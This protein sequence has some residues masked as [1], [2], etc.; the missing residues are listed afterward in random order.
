LSCCLLTFLL[1]SPLSF[2]YFLVAKKDADRE[3]FVMIRTGLCDDFVGWG[4]P[5]SLLRF[6]LDATLG[7]FPRFV[8]DDVIEFD[9]ESIFDKGIA[10]SI[11]LI[12]V[13]RSDK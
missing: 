6:F 10:R 1:T 9:K 2:R 5:D 7:V 12:E 3:V 13:E 8:F 11:P 4:D